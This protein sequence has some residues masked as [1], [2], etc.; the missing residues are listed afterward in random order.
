[1]KKIFFN[2]LTEKEKNNS[3]KYAVLFAVI[4][5]LIHSLLITELI[6]GLAFSLIT[7]I[8]SFSLIS[9]YFKRKK[10]KKTELIESQLPF[11]LI[12]LSSEINSGIEFEKALS[13]SAKNA[14]KELKKELEFTLNE[15]ENGTPVQ[16]ALLEFSKRNNSIQ[17]KKTMSILSNIYM[18]GNKKAGNT[19]KRLAKEML[20]KQKNKS[21]EFSQKIVLFSL[22]FIAVSAIIPA[23]FQAFITVGTLFMEIEFTPIQV[24]AITTI[25][26]PLIDLTVLFLIKESTPMHLK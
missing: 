1:M 10:Q 22:M 19:I 5:L 9:I 15:I 3:I 26:F 8:L 23:F 11:I 25:I 14:E 4:F 7:F 20:L 6:E 18:Q 21:K 2:N 16:K 17:I 13:D 24:I 12:P